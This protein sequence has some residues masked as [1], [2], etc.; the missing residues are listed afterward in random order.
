MLD[1]L[2]GW[3]TRHNR[4]EARL[5]QGLHLVVRAI[6]PPREELANRG[7]HVGEV[8]DMQA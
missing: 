4:Y 3:D 6:E 5:G 7:M 1:R 8:E 2:R